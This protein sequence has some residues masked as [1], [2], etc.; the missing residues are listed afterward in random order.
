[1]A[2]LLTALLVGVIVVI[3]VFPCIVFKLHTKCDIYVK[4]LL[5]ALYEK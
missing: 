2:T 3:P 5:Q 4:A 1:M